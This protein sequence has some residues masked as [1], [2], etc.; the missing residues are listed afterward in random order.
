MALVVKEQ[1]G[2]QPPW[3]SVVIPARNKAQNLAH[4]LPY[5][6]YI[7]SEVILVDGHSID[8]TITAA[9]QLLPSIRIIWGR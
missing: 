1:V 7:V 8:E 6:P 3:I 9:E 5:I 4:V 2:L